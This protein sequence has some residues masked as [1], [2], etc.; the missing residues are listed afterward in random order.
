MQGLLLE[1]YLLKISCALNDLFIEKL[2]GTIYYELVIK[3]DI[4][5]LL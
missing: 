3:I 5:R 1:K 4:D 2:S